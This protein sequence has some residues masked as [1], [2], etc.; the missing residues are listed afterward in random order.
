MKKLMDPQNGSSFTEIGA[1]HGGMKWKRRRWEHSLPEKSGP[2]SGKGS[3]QEE[4]TGANM[5][6]A[7]NGSTRVREPGN[8]TAASTTGSD[9]PQPFFPKEAL[10]LKIFL[11]EVS[12]ICNI[13]LI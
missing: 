6:S 3:S 7:G 2:P 10:N 9:V 13:I 11:I 4:T 12:L 5:H 1:Q 8:G